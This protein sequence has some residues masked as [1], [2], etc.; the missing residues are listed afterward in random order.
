MHVEQH[1]WVLILTT[2]RQHVKRYKRIRR[3][4]LREYSH[5][6]SSAKTPPLSASRDNLAYKSSSQTHLD[7]FNDFAQDDEE[8][9]GE[10][11][12]EDADAA[13][14][15]SLDDNAILSA[16]SLRN[17]PE[18]LNALILLRMMTLNVLHPALRQGADGEKA[19]WRSLVDRL[20][21][22]CEEQSSPS[23]VSGMPMHVGAGIE[24]GNRR[25]PFQTSKSMRL[26]VREWIVCR[27]AWPSIDKICQSDY[28]NQRI[29]E[30]AQRRITL[31][32]T[33][34]G[35]RTFLDGH[36]SNFPPAFGQG[37]NNGGDSA[38]GG[39]DGQPLNLTERSRYFEPLS[40]Y[41]RKVRSVVDA[42]AIRYQIVSELRRR[43]DEAKDLQYYEELYG[44]PVEVLK[45]YVKSLDV[46]RSKYEKRISAF[47]G[48]DTRSPE[49]PK[50]SPSS[51]LLP[52]SDDHSFKMEEKLTLRAMFDEYNKSVALG[53]GERS[54]SLFYFL[55][56]L[57]KREDRDGMSKVRFWLAAEK[58][59]YVVCVLKWYLRW[60]L[61]FK[62][63]GRTKTRL[64]PT[65]WHHPVRRAP[66]PPPTPPPQA[67]PRAPPRPAPPP[68]TP[69]S[70]P[71]P[72]GEVIGIL[73]RLQKEAS[74]IYTSFLSPTP[75]THKPLVDIG[76]AILLSAIE[77]FATQ[78]PHEIA[79]V[80][81]REFRSVAELEE[82]HDYKCVLVAQDMIF[83]ELQESF[84]G[85]RH[86]ESFFRWTSEE[87]KKRIAE[88]GSVG[89]SGEVIGF[90]GEGLLGNPNRRSIDGLSRKSEDGVL[91]SGRSGGGLSGGALSGGGLSGS[92][93]ERESAEKGGEQGVEEVIGQSVVLKVLLKEVANVAIRLTGIKVAKQQ[94]MPKTPSSPT[95]SWFSRR[96]SDLD[97]N[98]TPIA[99]PPSHFA[100]LGTGLG[101]T[102]TP[103]VDFN[104]TAADDFPLHD[105]D[106]D[107]LTSTVRKESFLDDGEDSSHAPGELLTTTTKL[108][109]LKEEIDKVM[110][111]IECLNTLNSF[112]VQ[113]S[114]GAGAQQQTTTTVFQTQ[115]MTHIIDQTKELLRQEVGDLTRQKAKL[116]SQET[117]DAII[118]G[119]CTVKIEAAFDD[120]VKRKDPTSGEGKKVTFY[121]IRIER[122]DT[123]SVGV[124]SSGNGGGGGASGWT[125]RRRYSDFW[126]LHRKLRER[127]G[128]VQEFE[129][130]GK[131]VG[132]WMKGKR[133]VKFAR[134]KSLE[135]YLQRLMDNPQICQSEELRTFLSST[136][137][138]LPSSLFAPSYR[139]AASTSLP[140]ASAEGEASES[141][142]KRTQ[143]KLAKF[144]KGRRRANSVD[145]FSDGRG[146]GGVGASAVVVVR[147]EDEGRVSVS[148]GRKSTPLNI[149]FG[150]GPRKSVLDA[151]TGGGGGAS[152]RGGGGSKM[153]TSPGQ[154]PAESPTTSSFGFSS[155]KQPHTPSSSLPR[156]PH[157]DSTTSTST[158]T[159]S[160][161]P[162]P[163][164]SS[165]SSSSSSSPSFDDDESPTRMSMSSG[166]GGEDDF[167]MESQGA[168]LLADPLFA[169]LIECWDFK[170]QSFWLRWGAAGM[171][172]GE[173]FGWREGIDSR[174]A[175][176][177][178]MLVSDDAIMYRLQQAVEKLQKGG[179]G[180]GSNGGGGGGFLQEYVPRPVSVQTATRTEAKAKL[181][182]SWPEAFARILG[183]ESAN[184]GTARLFDMVQNAT[185]NKHF[186]YSVVDAVVAGF[187]G[188]DVGGGE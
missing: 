180:G 5:K 162:V 93:W 39:G 188:G 136:A 54:T 21:Q 50:R 9:V 48:D 2:F 58:Y 64:A 36:F 67:R 134:I 127:W 89:S 23:P 68:P 156:T 31:Q 86:S 70:T 186:V 80:G 152:S 20:W 25:E 44:E 18:E 125:V 15:S 112:I 11:R 42:K 97:H 137:P 177:L 175:T 45:R 153:T 14:H 168:S 30:K 157:R 13:H 143:T 130:P 122:E 140:L 82:S 109:Q 85:F 95:K 138:T 114:S 49:K 120:I 148:E 102:V 179:E 106:K 131:G 1:L 79:G 3:E 121:L 139:A 116:H 12:W 135:R 110:L 144:I 62:E 169:V 129:L 74:K 159:R 98:S 69:E 167:M 142:V 164:I 46:L 16:E 182:N 90:G 126:A 151:F 108:Q 26:L 28:L 184:E 32:K 155:T 35:F 83:R 78:P 24:A 174:L 119:Q 57:E 81:G 66:P 59:R 88:V 101:G 96:E 166:V 185:L 38:A 60:G 117:K 105:G 113:S 34:R 76:N 19:Y 133:E 17:N 52:R 61:R 27:L 72:E 92:S 41:S 56:Y 51:A 8:D 132:V 55:D 170:E 10:T 33:I 4:V 161:S 107:I 147:G 187:V 47:T 163:S 128:V 43:V 172:V 165:I 150:H 94:P 123:G 149:G 158:A 73:I 178:R 183:P 141:A 37:N 99:T 63:S 181:L 124:S 84:E 75:T 173:T 7:D 115:V 40:K 103:P 6:L 111:E 87:E 22:V 118:P 29:I 145:P 176:V 146:S 53:T 160:I 71:E 154:S 100:V 65:A 171:L 104:I 91:S 77:E